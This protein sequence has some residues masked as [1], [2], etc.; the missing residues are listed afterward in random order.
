MC[1]F[2][3]PLGVEQLRNHRFQSGTGGGSFG[4]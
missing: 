2:V 3:S 1:V 4:V